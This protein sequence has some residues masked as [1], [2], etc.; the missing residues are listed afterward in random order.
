MPQPLPEVCKCSFL[1][2]YGR[3]LGSGNLDVFF[4]ET[5][6][7]GFSRPSNESADNQTRKIYSN[8]EHR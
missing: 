4:S 2:N 3:N 1:N 8:S 6:E 7:T 5:M